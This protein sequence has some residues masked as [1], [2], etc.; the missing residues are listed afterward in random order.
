MHL[1]I[2]EL[3]QEY[4]QAITPQELAKFLALDRRTII[5][6]AHK[7][8][9]VEVAPGTWRFFK[10]RVMEVLN[11]QFDNETW[12]KTVPGQC[13]S[14]WNNATE[15]FSRRFPAVEKRSLSLGRK[16][17]KGVGKKEVQDK[18]GVFGDR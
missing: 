17:T 16:N 12:E 18:Y 8:G 3:E 7:W 9:G 10:K 1:M 15:D 2:S 6:Y 14:K 4:G 13:D 11:A 5:K